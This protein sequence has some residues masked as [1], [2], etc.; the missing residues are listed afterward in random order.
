MCDTE[1]DVFVGFRD[2]MKDAWDRDHEPLFEI[3]CLNCGVEGLKMSSWREDPETDD[4][5]RR[6]VIVFRCGECKSDIEMYMFEGWD[7]QIR[8][9]LLLLREQREKKSGDKGNSE[10]G[11]EALFRARAAMMQGRDCGGS[12]KGWLRR[13]F[14]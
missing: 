14:G 5:K 6:D 4:R 13:L 8:S 10:G 1:L 2:Y 9:D 3:T 7:I 11:C 12:K